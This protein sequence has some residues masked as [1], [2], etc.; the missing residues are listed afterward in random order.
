MFIYIEKEHA[1]ATKTAF[2]TGVLSECRKC[3]QRDIDLIL[4]RKK[5]KNIPHNKAV[6]DVYY[7]KYDIYD[8]TAD[9]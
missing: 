3:R 8:T 7:D 9:A 2:E 5:R 4:C 6:C 1:G